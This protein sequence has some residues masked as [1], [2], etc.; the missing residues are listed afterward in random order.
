MCGIA[1]LWHF[2]GGRFDA[3]PMANCLVHRGPDD[4]GTYSNDEG[5]SLSFR[6]LA[7]VDL[8]EAGAQPMWSA[9]RRYVMVFNGEIFNFERLRA[10][11]PQQAWRGHSDTEVLLACIEEW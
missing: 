9:S 3:T 6:R 5:V 8:T 7:I 1:G 2:E 11:L 4:S 10:R